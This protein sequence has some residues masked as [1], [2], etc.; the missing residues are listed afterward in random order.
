MIPVLQHAVEFVEK[1]E[2]QRLGWVIL[3]QPSAPF[4]EVADI[5]ETL[6]LA[7]AGGCDSVISVVQIWAVHPILMKRIENDQLQPYCIEEKEGTRRQDYQPPAY[8]RNGAIYLTKRDVLMEQH[9]IWGQVIRPYVMPEDRS[10]G[11][12]SEIDM[13]LVELLMAE[14]LRKDRP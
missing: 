2:N 6:R 8:M 14:R 5:E 7:Q 9:S 11:I 12:D 3:L 10:V 13:K 1:E 4:R